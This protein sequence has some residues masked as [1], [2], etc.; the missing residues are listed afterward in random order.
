[1]SIFAPNITDVHTHHPDARD[2]IISV[3]PDEPRR[4]DLFYSVGIHPWDSAGAGD[5]DIEAVRRAVSEPNVL[6]VGECGLDTLRGAPI[7]RQMQLLE[8][9]AIIAEE[10]HKPLM[11]HIVKAW[12]QMLALKKR[13]RPTVPWIIHGFRGGV[14]QARQ[15]VDAGLYLSLG[16]RHNPDVAAA[17]HPDRLLH[18]T[19]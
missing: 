19:D 14:Q 16:A 10:A 11:L 18:E 6:A 12:D 5:D 8:A 15:L 4:A 2:A 17:I 13:L 1:M 3:S 7:E 9:Q